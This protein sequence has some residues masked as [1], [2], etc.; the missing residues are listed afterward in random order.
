MARRTTTRTSTVGSRRRVFVDTGGWYAVAS[1]D[2]RYHL[3][4]TQY[5]RD[6]LDAGGHLLT[7]DYVLDETLTRL[8][9]DTG[10]GVAAAFWERAQQAQQLGYLTFLRVDEPTWNAAI[11]LFFQ[12]R[13][14]LFSFTDCTSFVLAQAHR[15]DEVFGFDAHFLMFGLALRPGLPP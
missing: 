6:L 2:D 9:Y 5:Y 1:R 10:P 15:V 8:R 11:S 7:S 13:D 14:Q 3:P 4:A 12:Y